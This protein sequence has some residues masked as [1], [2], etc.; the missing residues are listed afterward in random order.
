V[1]CATCGSP[2]IQP[3]S[4]FRYCPSCGIATEDD[5]ERA[6]RLARRAAGKALVNA[7]IDD[8]IQSRTGGAHAC[9]VCGK[10]IGSPG[11][12]IGCHAAEVG[13]PE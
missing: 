9:T 5:S 7:L 10:H 2:T 8:A 12:C 13:G 4:G 11:K 6:G 3:A 1:T